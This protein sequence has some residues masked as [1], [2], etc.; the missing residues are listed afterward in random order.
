M[1]GDLERNR[2]LNVLITIFFLLV[3]RLGGAWKR[4]EADSVMSKLFGLCTVNIYENQ[5]MDR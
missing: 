2:C 1:C 5:R 4:K 3:T